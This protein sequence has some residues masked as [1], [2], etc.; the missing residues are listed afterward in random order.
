MQRNP[1][2][3]ERSRIVFVQFGA[4]NWSPSTC[5]FPKNPFKPDKIQTKSSEKKI[6]KRGL[7]RFWAIT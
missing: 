2:E 7:G 5:F 1:I 4:S 3:K 6:Q